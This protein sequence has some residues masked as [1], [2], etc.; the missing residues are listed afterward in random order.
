VRRLLAAVVHNW[1][2]K[3]AAVGLAVLLYVA[4][5][6][7]Q[8][9]K[10][11]RGQVLID[12]RN[13][14]AGAVL[15]DAVQ[16]VT[17]IRYFAPVDAASR[18]TGD[19]FSAWIDLSAA[20][21]D[22]SNDLLVQVTVTSRDPQVQVF[23]W[24]PRQVSI[25]LDPLRQKVVPVQVDRGAIPPGLQV[26]DPVVDTAQVTV[27]GTQSTVSQVVAAVARVR[28]DPS[29]VTIDQ[30]VDLEP[31][32]ARGVGVGQVRLT[33]SSVRVKILV[34][35]QLQSRT[36]PVNAIV[37][38]TPATGYQLSS[39]DID[40]VAVS[41]EGDVDTLAVL[42]R[43]DTQPL[44][45]TGASTDISETVALV[46]PAGVDILGGPSIR[47][48]AHIQAMTAT[49]TFSVGM[50]LSGAQGDRAYALS[51]DQVLVTLGGSAADLAA[52]QGDTL[53][54]IVDVDGLGPGTHDVVVKTTL[55]AGISLVAIAPAKVTV[56]VGPVA[57][58]SAPA[59]ASPVP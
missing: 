32:D 14:P 7:S 25:H 20:S 52:L 18:V 55:P 5:A 23:E 10:D 13:Q 38:G 11:W 59:P 17:S 51:T 9:S 49:R 21:P 30:E 36:L 46:V 4:L 15:V 16:Y 29:G 33:P 24:S 27:S 26:R 44:S 39:I 35:S 12:V 2:L 50:V 57:S 37:T 8:N 56:T 47:I 40:P 43:I 28:I 1:P 48:V 54:V 6:L 58:P 22:A 41:V 45:V 34:G 19:T 53:T 3:V 42:T 31:I